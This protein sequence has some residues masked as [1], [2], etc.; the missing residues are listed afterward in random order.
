MQS[1]S[2]LPSGHQAIP[3][4]ALRH[5]EQ[6]SHTRPRASDRAVGV[7]IDLQ[8][9]PVLTVTEEMDIEWVLDAMFR[10]GVRIVLVVRDGTRY[11]RAV[12]SAKR[13]VP[14]ILAA[15]ELVPRAAPPE[16]PA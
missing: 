13:D 16:I 7:M 1:L 12:S 8:R 5:S 3:L 9:D 6:S 15:S 10:L 14:G 11:W 4:Q 2:A